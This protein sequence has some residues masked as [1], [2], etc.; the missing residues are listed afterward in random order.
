LAG[1][2]LE[3]DAHDGPLHGAT[4]SGLDWQ[5]PPAHGVVGS[6]SEDAGFDSDEQEP[7]VHE[8]VDSG[9]E[10]AGFG[11]DEQEP[12]VH[13][14]VGSVTEDVGFGSDE[15]EPLVHEAVDSG[16]EDVGF[17]SDELVDSEVLIYSDLTEESSL[18]CSFTAGSG[19]FL[20]S[21]KVLGASSFFGA[22][23]FLFKTIVL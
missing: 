11:S 6:F 16:L 10:D 17:D 22:V 1:L 14:V 4:G 12:P 13:G 2:G 3:E 21:G 20:V 8:L 18:L 5:E 7:L 9:L 15:Q 19:P 23:Y